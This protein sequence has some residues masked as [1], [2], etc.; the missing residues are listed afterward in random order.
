MNTKRRLACHPRVFRTY[1]NA[2]RTVPFSCYAKETLIQLRDAYNRVYKSD[3]I[4]SKYTGLRLWKVLRNR[5]EKAR[6]CDRNH[7]NDEK[8]FLKAFSDPALRRKLERY[9]FA[10]PRPQSWKKNKNEW[11]T[12]FNILHVMEQ[13]EEVYKEFEFLGP[14]TIDFERVIDHACVSEEICKMS[15]TDLKKKGKTQIGIIL[16]LDTYDKGGS[17]WVALYINL[18]SKQAYFFDSVGHR[19][20]Q[21]VRAFIAR[22]PELSFSENKVPHQRSTSECGMYAM[23]FII[24]MLTGLEPGSVQPPLAVAKRWAFFQERI[25]DS[26]MMQRRKELFSEPRS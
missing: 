26:V 17:H 11:L 10:P 6:F 21:Q 18:S 7:P 13:Y 19:A 16:N 23:N 1:R 12:N 2:S 14:S 3:P 5:F 22:F 20:P 25:D 9:V 8:C 15:L 24:F 4:S